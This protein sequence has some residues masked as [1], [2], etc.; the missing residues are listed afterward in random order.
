MC[1]EKKGQTR[2]S[3]VV[4]RKGVLC[5]AIVVGLPLNAFL[6]VSGTKLD[7]DSNTNKIK[8]CLETAPPLETQLRGG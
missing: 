2:K 1:N 8:K 6:I 7:S 4:L 3:R 5:E